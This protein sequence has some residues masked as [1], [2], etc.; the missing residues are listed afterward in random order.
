[1]PTSIYKSLKFGDLEPTRLTIQLANRSVVQPL[2]VLEDVL[3]QDETSEK[4]ST[5]ILQRL[6]LMTARTKIDVHVG[7]LSIEFG[8]HL[9]QFNIFEVIK[10]PTEDHSLFGIDLIDELIEEH[11]QLN[12]NSDDTLDFAR[13]TNIF[14]CLGSVTAKANCNELREVRDLSNSKD[15]IT[16]L[17]D[18]G[19]EEELLDLLDQVC[20]HEDPEHSNNVRVQVVRIEK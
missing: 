11:L 4:G 6:F 12:A 7:T 2:G 1:M 3:V 8:D 17:V 14:D 9:V 15:G 20:K 10:H 19:P 18:L 16:D 13:D 5:L